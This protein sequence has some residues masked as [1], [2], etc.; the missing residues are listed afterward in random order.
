MVGTIGMYGIHVLFSFNFRVILEMMG[1][2]I[3][4]IFYAP[5]YLHLLMI[6]AFCKIDD[7]SW[8]TKGL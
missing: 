8:G 2:T 1:A 4:Y 3:H 6:Y 5:T 7:F